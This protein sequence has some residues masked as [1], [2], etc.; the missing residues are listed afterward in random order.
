MPW[1]KLCGRGSAQRI[2]PNS[3]IIW[4]D[5]GQNIAHQK[6]TPEKSSSISSGIFQC[7]FSD[8]FQHNFIVLCRF[9]KFA[10]GLSPF[11]WIFTGI[12]QLV[13]SGIFQSYFTFVI[14]GV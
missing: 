2:H 11:Q 5:W 1:N 10:E 13:F 6:S 9:L 3:T 12:V 4:I 14:S 8:I 7:M